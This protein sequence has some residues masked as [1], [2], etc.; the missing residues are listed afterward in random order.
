MKAADIDYQS[1]SLPVTLRDTVTYLK[2]YARENSIITYV[3][4]GLFLA[5][6][7]FCLFLFIGASGDIIDVSLVSLF[8]AVLIIGVPLALYVKVK[9]AIKI[10]R[11]AV[12]NGFLYRNDAAPDHSGLIFNEGDSRMI[13]NEFSGGFELGEFSV[14][15]YK[16]ETGSG[17]HRKT[18]KYGFARI[19]LPR[20]LPNIVLDAKSNNFL[21][22]FSN[23]PVSFGR[24]QRL[25]LEGNFD[26][27]YDLYCPSTHKTD[28]LYIF[29]PDI[30]EMMISNGKDFDIEIIDN[31]L[32]LYKS[33]YFNLTNAAVI[34]N[35]MSVLE[36]F[37]AKLQRRTDYYADSRVGDRAL[38]QVARSGKRLRANSAYAWVAIVVVVYVV[39]RVVST[40]ISFI[41]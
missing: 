5:G 19:D 17:K 10:E 1:F 41:F 29:T 7:T 35:V 13:I 15:N 31:Q 26:T 37:D 11:F 2:K 40:A 6:L 22:R 30:M 28:A 3:S 21:G 8:V 32:F 12:S 33:G 23:L 18:H 9:T 25:S 36:I 34:A 24:D 38:D 4:V 16:Y 14:G 39:Y 27:S 20:H